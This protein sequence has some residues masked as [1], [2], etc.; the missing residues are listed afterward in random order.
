MML[1]ALEFLQS[2]HSAVEMVGLL[3]HLFIADHNIWPR[4][5][6][7]SRTRGKHSKRPTFQSDGEDEGVYTKVCR[8]R[9]EF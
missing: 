9:A 1:L 5:Q 2:T 3:M 8:S 7:Q 6:V 4:C